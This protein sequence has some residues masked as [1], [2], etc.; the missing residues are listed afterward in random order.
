MTYSHF[1]SFEMVGLW[2]YLKGLA[3]PWRISHGAMGLPQGPDQPLW[4]KI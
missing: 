1:W 4:D 2:A 3:T